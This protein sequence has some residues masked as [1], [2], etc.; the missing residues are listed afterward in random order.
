[1]N[2][3]D[4]EQALGGLLPTLNGPLPPELVDTALSLLARSRSV[5]HS[6]KPDEEIARPYACAQLACERSKIRLNLPSITSRPPCPPRIYKKLL[7][8]LETALPATASASVPGTPRKNTSYNPNTPSRT[9]PKTPTGA[10]KTPRSTIK[11]N[12]NAKDTPEW[13]MPPI[14]ALA[15]SFDHPAAVPHIYTGVESTMSLLALMAAASVPDTPSKRPRRAAASAHATTNLSETRILAL[16]AVI[17]FYVIS[18]IQDKD[19]TPDQYEEW[20]SRAISILLQ[21]KAD[22][23]TGEEEVATE[24]E[25]LMPL[26]QAEGWLQ[27]EWFLNVMPTESGQEMEGVE[28]TADHTNGTKPKSWKES[29]GSENIGLGTMMQDATDY[30]SERKREDYRRWKAGIIAMVEEI[31]AS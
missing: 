20:R 8:Y 6:L 19:I 10:R 5:A 12:V 7:T 23:N 9:T 26:A 13:V 21:T 27:M 11:Q 31:E 16:I 1:M 15:K 30:L 2:K 29:F 14:R 25:E 28:M 17:S 4:I 3:A 22:A 24:I 18:R